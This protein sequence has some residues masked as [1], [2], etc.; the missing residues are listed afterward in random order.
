MKKRKSAKPATMAL[1]QSFGDRL[2]RGEI[3]LPE[4]YEQ[5]ETKAGQRSVSAHVPDVRGAKGSPFRAIDILTVMH[6]AGTITT[7]WKTAGKQFSDDFAIAGL[8]PLRAADVSR[9]PGQHG[10][11][12]GTLRRT[13]A[14]NR[15]WNAIQVLGGFQSPAGACAWA[16]LGLGQ[17]L[18]EWSASTGWRKTPI[19]KMAASGILIGTLGALAAHYGLDKAVKR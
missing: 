15:V 5:R 10:I 8:E 19:N 18:T 6:R 1:S 4:H 2:R 16:V 13:D 7:A 12:S 3:E 17:S 14:G 9:I 11:D